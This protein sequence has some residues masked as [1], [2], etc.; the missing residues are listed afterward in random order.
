MWNGRTRP[1]SVWA[2]GGE[3]T[4]EAYARLRAREW[5]APAL[6][7]APLVRWPRAVLPG[8]Q[9]IEIIEKNDIRR[10]EW[11]E[12]LYPEDSKSLVCVGLRFLY[13]ENLFYCNLLL[14]FYNQKAILKL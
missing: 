3:A 14:N 7:L 4:R 9:L 6:V 12:F 13:I 10:A 5:A 11:E 8:H 1:H 2:A